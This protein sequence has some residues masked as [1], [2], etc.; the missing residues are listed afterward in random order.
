MMITK[1]GLMPFEDE[2]KGHKPKNTDGPWKL[3]K[4]RN[5]PFS[6][7]RSNQPRWYLDF[8]PVMQ[9]SDFWFTET[10]DNKFMSF[11]DLDGF[12]K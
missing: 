4:A 8:N 9:I 1:T 5:S 10:W 3:K 11:Q 2:W 12:K 7:S 6:S